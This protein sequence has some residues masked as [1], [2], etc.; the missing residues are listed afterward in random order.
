MKKLEKKVKI[1]ILRMIHLEYSSYLDSNKTTFYTSGS[2]KTQLM[3]PS[4]Y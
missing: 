4:L 2:I 3:N 1:Y